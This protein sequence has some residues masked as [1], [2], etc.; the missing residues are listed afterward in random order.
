[1][2]IFDLGDIVRQGV[3][4][5]QPEVVR[6]LLDEFEQNL[7]YLESLPCSYKAGLGEYV[8]NKIRMTRATAKSCWEVDADRYNELLHRSDDYARRALA[9]RANMYDNVCGHCD[10]CQSRRKS[11]PPKT[12]FKDTQ[13]CRLSL[14]TYAS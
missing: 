1:M 11:W 10:S 7:L 9:V 14:T 4:K 5:C 8:I 6:R 13:G 3:A 2:D 12:K